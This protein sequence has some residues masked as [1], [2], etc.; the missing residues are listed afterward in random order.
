M[1]T[2]STRLLVKDLTGEAALLTL[3]SALSEKK[4]KEGYYL[5][6]KTTGSEGIRFKTPSLKE[7]SDVVEKLF[8][9]GYATIQEYEENKFK[10]I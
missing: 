8:A 6:V 1:Q 4:Y 3:Q 10:Q 2:E 5:L 7:A 9:T